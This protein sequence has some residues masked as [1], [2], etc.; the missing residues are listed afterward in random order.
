MPVFG[1]RFAEHPVYT[2]RYGGTPLFSETYAASVSYIKEKYEAHAT[3]F[4]VD[5]LI[6]GV[7]LDNGG[8]VYGEYRPCAWTQI[9]AGA[10]VEVSDWQHKYRGTVTA[11]QWLPS[12]GLMLQA[13]VQ[14]VNPHVG[15]YG[16]RQIA[17]YLMT[18]YFVTDAILIDLGLGHYDE[19][20]RIRNLDRNNVDLNVHWFV[21]SHFEAML[22]TRYE[23]LGIRGDGGPFGSWAMLQGHYRL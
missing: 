20:I 11:K 23:Q 8:A 5:P 4:I 19:N 9:G 1:L 10:M 6:D 18:S 15:G 16:Y 13:E 22:V 17:G 3:G 7:R 2:R 21:S 14:L 12:P